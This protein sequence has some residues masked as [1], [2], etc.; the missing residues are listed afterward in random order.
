MC[1]TE[2]FFIP[3]SSYPFPSTRGSNFVLSPRG[4]NQYSKAT[5]SGINY[6][7][8]AR[9]CGLYFIQLKYPDLLRSAADIRFGTREN[10]L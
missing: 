4:W 7:G 5:A 1:F 3:L 9:N 8:M 10:P 6:G 2:E